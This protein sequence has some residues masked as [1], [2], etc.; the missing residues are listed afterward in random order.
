MVIG[1]VVMIVSQHHYRH[2]RR[3]YPGVTPYIQ[4][5]VQTSATI[6]QLLAWSQFPRTEETP[7]PPPRKPVLLFIPLTFVHDL[8]WLQIM[9]E[10]ENGRKCENN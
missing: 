8:P 7:V 3:L 2:G 1:T 6:R 5:T 4:I 10:A 9:S